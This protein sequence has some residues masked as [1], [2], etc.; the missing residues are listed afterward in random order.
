MPDE[1][2]AVLVVVADD[3]RDGVLVERADLLGVRGEHAEQQPVGAGADVLG[4]RRVGLLEDVEDQ[5]GLLDRARQLGGVGVEARQPDRAV[6]LQPRRPAAAPRPSVASGASSPPVRRQQRVHARRVPELHVLGQRARVLA[7]DRRDHVARAVG[8]QLGAQH[9]RARARGRSPA[10]PR[11]ARP[12]AARGR[13]RARS[14]SRNEPRR[15]CSTSSLASSTATSVSE[16]TAA[17][18]RNSAASVARLGRRRAAARRRRPARRPSWIGTSASDAG[19]HRRPAGRARGRRRTARS[20]L[21]RSPGRRPGA[22]TAAPSRGTTIATGAAR[23]LGG[24]LGHAAAGRRRP[25]R[26][27]PSRGGRRAG[28]RPATGGARGAAPSAA[29]RLR[30]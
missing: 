19:G 6:A 13:G 2:G 10:G 26:R 3:R 5:L 9:D 12:R 18:C 8:R 7:G 28:A 23:R 17:R 25:A 22:T 20:A 4:D 16:A 15:F 11:A 1:V 24:E 14:S 27:R 29:P 30:P 21:E